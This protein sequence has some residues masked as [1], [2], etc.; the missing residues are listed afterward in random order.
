MSKTPPCGIMV[1][2]LRIFSVPWFS[3]LEQVA[4]LCLP[5]IW[6]VFSKVQN[7]RVPSKMYIFKS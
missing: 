3:K 2:N 5:K 6:G 4:S 1:G 7:V